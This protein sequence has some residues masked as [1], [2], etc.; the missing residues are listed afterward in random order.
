M[1]SMLKYLSIWE[2]G[3]EIVAFLMRLS[4]LNTL[5]LVCILKIGRFN[6]LS[7]NL[8][9]VYVRGMSKVSIT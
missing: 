8:R 6:K 2:K 7:N 1:Y 3:V 5:I 9:T 4:R